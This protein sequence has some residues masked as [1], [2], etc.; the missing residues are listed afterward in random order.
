MISLEENTENQR[1]WQME[2]FLY[3]QNQ[4]IKGGKTPFFTPMK[5]AKKT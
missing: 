2:T 3:R 4:K 1:F 5:K